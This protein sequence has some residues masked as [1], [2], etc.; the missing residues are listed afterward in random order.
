MNM[1]ALLFLL[2]TPRRRA[3][4]CAALLCWGLWCAPALGDDARLEVIP[5]KHLSAEQAVALI[6]PLLDKQD[7]VSGANNQLIVRAAPARL[8]QVKQALAKFD[9]APQRLLVSVKQD[10]DVARS[11]N[12]QE[13]SARVRGGKA[14]ATVGRAPDESAVE[15]RIAR[16]DAHNAD[17]RVQQ[18]RVLEGNRA[19]IQIGQS[20]PVAESKFEVGGGVPHTFNSIT[21]KDVT[22]GFAVLPRLN[23][24]SVTL[25]IAPRHNAVNERGGGSIDIQQARTTV[26]GRL[27]EWIDIGGALEERSAD[28]AGIAYSTRDL[29]AERR[30]ILVK[31]DKDEP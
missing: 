2:V 24:D 10:V 9:V 19:F 25:E 3:R 31:V 1:T 17:R 16:R 29:R 6:K 18:L 20:I 22:S 11:Q 26:S 27:G 8:E 15:V 12:E 30:R 14:D 23:G 21:Y 28:G 4:T 7:A 5:L 13:V